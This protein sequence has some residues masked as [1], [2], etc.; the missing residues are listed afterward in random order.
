MVWPNLV[1][2]GIK[3]WIFQLF[4]CSTNVATVRTDKGCIGDFEQLL[5]RTVDY[6]HFGRVSAILPHSIYV[7][8]SLLR[9]TSVSI[10]TLLNRETSYSISQAQSNGARVR[11]E[12]RVH[13]YN[14]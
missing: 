2:P 8:L 1:S 10:S 4:A 13:Y 5:A 11:N 14:V 9:Y 3:R 6:W 7:L 12:A